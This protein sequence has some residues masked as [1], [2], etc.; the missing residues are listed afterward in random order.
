VKVR[1]AARGAARDRGIRNGTAVDAAVV[2][3]GAGFSGVGMAIR[4]RQAGIDDFVILEKAAEAGG[5]WRDNRYPGCACDV[6]SFMYSFSFEQNPDWTRMFATQPEIWAYLE[7]CIDKYGVRPHLRHN[8][9]VVGAEFDEETGTWR[10]LVDGGPAVTCRAVVL[11][12]GPLHLPA[13]PDLPGLENFAGRTFHSSAWDH[14]Y[15]L[16]GKRVAVI[17]TV[18]SAIQFVPQIAPLVARLDL[19]QRTPPWV[20]PKQD[21][22]IGERERRLYRRVPALQRLHRYAIYWLLESRLPGFTS[23]QAILRFAQRIARWNIRRSISDPVLR[24]KLTPHYAMGCKRVLISSD[25]YPAVARDNVEVVAEGI[26]EV[27]PDGI[28]SADGRFRPVDAIIYGTGF[29]V[30]D[31]LEG[32]HLVGRNGLKLQDAWADGMEAYLGVTV[33]G[34]PN[35][36]VL[37]GPNSGLGHNS[38]VFMAESQINYVMQA[39]RLLGTRRAGTVEV[40]GGVQRRYNADIQGLLAGTVWNVGGCR[41]WYLDRNGVNRALWPTFTWR[42]WLRTRRLDPADYELTPVSR[43]RWSGPTG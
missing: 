40:R 39:L 18:A 10:V 19:Y 22:A 41:S 11:A 21:R 35:A 33:A 31:A 23:R 34:F 5:T 26:A 4:L 12:T 24:R 6:Q 28:L 9:P 13:Y 14:D 20:L 27:R 2:I 43:P 25:Y 16:A 42:Y 1:D 3:V 37:L 15:D 36:F 29:H 38:V 30:T 17:G 7:R 32:F 8:S